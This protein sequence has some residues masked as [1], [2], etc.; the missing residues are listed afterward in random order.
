M[1]IRALIFDVDGTLAETEDYHRRA[2]NQAFA[3]AG[4]DWVW[5]RET[6]GGLLKVAGGRERVEANA[7]AIGQSGIDAAALHRRKTEIYKSFMRPGEIELRP[8][9]ERII[10]AA[11]CRGLR[12]AIATTT[13]R[14][15][16][17]GLL[18]T[19]LGPD[20][21]G[22]FASIRSGEDVAAKKPDPEVYLKVLD[23]LGLAP[24]DCVAFEDSANG[25]GATSA[26]GLVTVVTP[27][28]YTADD[29]FT[30][31]TVLLRNLDEPFSTALFKPRT[32][33]SDLS[34]DMDELIMGTR[35]PAPGRTPFN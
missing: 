4:M 9:V 17:D 21:I 1:S 5:S 23:D 27:S 6:Y 7:A 18:A 16:V 31:A 22:W 32:S 3:E 19:T 24:R 29:D 12:L 2:F 14:S 33:L 30:G 20:S 35:S 13:S 25:I 28:I 15:N 11:R 10:K 8:G 26:V 34:P